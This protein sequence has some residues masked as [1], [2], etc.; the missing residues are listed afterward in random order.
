MNIR[1]VS[2]PDGGPGFQG[3]FAR[4]HVGDDGGRIGFPLFC[5]LVRCLGTFPR[6]V[7]QS[8]GHVC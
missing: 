5:S 6:L 7:N 2:T 3:T 1:D 4:S 8:R